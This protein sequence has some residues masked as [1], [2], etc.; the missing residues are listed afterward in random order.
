[1]CFHGNRVCCHGNWVCRHGNMGCSYGNK[2][3][4]VL[5]SQQVC[6]VLSWNRGVLSLNR[7][8]LCVEMLK[9]W[10]VCCHGNVAL[11]AAPMFMLCDCAPKSHNVFT[12]SYNSDINIPLETRIHMKLNSNSH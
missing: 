12:Q 1:M 11:Y 7:G 3:G 10:G 2:G 6:C 8:L 9:G 5:S 4:F